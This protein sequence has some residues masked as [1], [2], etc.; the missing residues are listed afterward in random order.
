MAMVL[1]DKIH[2]SALSDQSSR[3]GTP[4]QSARLENWENPGAD[5]ATSLRPA[6]PEYLLI[7][8]AGGHEQRSLQRA[9]LPRTASDSLAKGLW[10]LLAPG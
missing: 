7:Q 1:R 10:M 8:T 4:D 3:T 9:M 6:N 5:P 2:L